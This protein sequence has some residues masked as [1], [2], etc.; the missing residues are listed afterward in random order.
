MRTNKCSDGTVRIALGL[1]AV[2]AFCG[3]ASGQKTTRPYKSDTVSEIMA[4]VAGADAD[5]RAKAMESLKQRLSNASYRVSEVKQVARL[6]LTNKRYDEI[7][8]L[9]I[10]VIA[11]FPGEFRTIENVLSIRVKALLAQNKAQEALAMAKSYF[12]IA[13]MEGTSDAVLLIAECLIAA[14]PE[15]RLAYEK[16]KEEQVAGATTQPTTRPMKS[17]TLGG[18]KVEP[19]PYDDLLNNFTGEDYAALLA[20][21]NLLLLGD[22]TRDARLIFERMYTIAQPHQLAE[23]SECLARLIKAEDGT[24]GRANVFVLSIRPKKPNP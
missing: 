23:A 2:L 1:V 21:G 12:N 6:L 18:I 14:R 10:F 9:A 16:F 17:A 15:D 20:R 7:H 8:D 11:N 3:G 5:A 19:K 24:I 4:A 22:K 13:S